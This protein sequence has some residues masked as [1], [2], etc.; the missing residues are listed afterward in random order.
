MLKGDKISH[1]F[2]IYTKE[3]TDLTSYSLMT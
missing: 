2:P 3:L 1:D